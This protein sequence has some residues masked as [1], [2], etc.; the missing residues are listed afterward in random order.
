[1]PDKRNIV[2]TSINKRAA[3]A[4]KK[5]RYKE[6]G[7]GFE[8]ELTGKVFGKPI[9]KQY[10]L[11]NQLGN[12]ILEDL[13]SIGEDPEDALKLVRELGDID[14]LDPHTRLKIYM[15][16]TTLPVP[17]SLIDDALGQPG[18]GQSV[19]QMM[20]GQSYV[21]DLETARLK[22]RQTI[23]KQID[24]TGRLAYRQQ[25]EL[26]DITEKL[27]EVEMVDSG[28][29]REARRRNRMDR[30]SIDASE[31]LDNARPGTSS[32]YMGPQKEEI[33]DDTPTSKDPLKNTAQS[34]FHAVRRG[35][36]LVV[37]QGPN[38][39]V[40]RPD[41]SGKGLEISRQY[42]NAKKD[43]QGRTIPT[44][45][46][47]KQDLVPLTQ[48]QKSNF[49]KALAEQQ[50]EESNDVRRRAA[51]KGAISTKAKRVAAFE[52]LES[53]GKPFGTLS[54]GIRAAG[55]TAVATGKLGTM[56]EPVESVRL[57]GRPATPRDLKRVA[58]KNI[59]RGGNFRKTKAD[60]MRAARALSR[61]GGPAALIAL[62]V[63]LGGGAMVGGSSDSA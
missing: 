35:S 11:R 24:G 6:Q 1:M 42:F 63:L 46:S 21:K 12:R 29:I 15:S 43:F 47:Y 31:R 33:L 44:A 57:G 50:M 22:E 62:A 16:R 5:K 49:I 26:Q 48:D 3:A 25:A 55:M 8:D 40:V 2:S 9:K 27:D 39:F 7:R 60:M 36:T 51:I 38:V 34:R 19:A 28:D 52:R 13:V 37:D 56:D 4:R 20:E 18:P 10:P 32:P 45:G 54:P 17:K 14:D 41:P 58:E 53:T 61:K 30:E 59:G 23:L